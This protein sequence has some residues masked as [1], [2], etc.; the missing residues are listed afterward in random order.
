MYDRTLPG[1]R[2]G[3]LEVLVGVWWEEA[4]VV[5]A[6][7][8]VKGFCERAISQIDSA[9]SAQ[10]NLTSTEVELSDDMEARCFLNAALV[11]GTV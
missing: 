1:A 4:V 6:R 11:R 5:V 7:E 9:L 2:D 8:G 3:C 10:Y